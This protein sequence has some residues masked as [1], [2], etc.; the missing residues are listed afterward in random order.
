MDNLR[1]LNLLD[2]LNENVLIKKKPLLGICLGMQLMSKRSEEGN[3]EGL[4]WF[5]AEVV[6]FSVRQIAI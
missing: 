5:D 3:A 4:G 2:T 6:H 1:N